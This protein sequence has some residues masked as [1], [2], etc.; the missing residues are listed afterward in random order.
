M[1]TFDPEHAAELAKLNHDLAAHDYRRYY[2]ENGEGHVYARA[3]WVVKV[4]GVRSGHNDSPFAV[5][6]I[7][8]GWGKHHH[9]YSSLN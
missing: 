2:V 9:I 3:E 8:T 5:F 4:N 6:H 7:E 1:P